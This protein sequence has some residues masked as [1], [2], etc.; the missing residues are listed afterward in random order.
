[1]TPEYWI[2]LSAI[3]ALI[4]ASAFFSGSETAL[5]AA[6][7]ARMHLLEKNG[8]ARAATVNALIARRDRLIGALLIGNNL[9]NILASVL[10]TSF[11]LKMFGDSGLAIATVAMTVVIVIFAEITPKS[12][13]ISSADKFA[14]AVAPAVNLIVTVLT[15]FASVTSFIVRVLLRPF[16]IRFDDAQ[17]MLSAHEEI[18]GAVE[19]LHREGSVVRDD[20]YRLGGILDLHE[21][22]VSDVM[23][24]RTKM[25]SINCDDPVDSIVRQILDSPY[26][27][28]PVWKNE[29][30]NI[31]GI[32]HAKDVLRFVGANED[33]SKF[34]IMKIAAKPW[35]VPETT[36]LQDQLNAFLRKK[37][38]IALVVD[39]YGEVKGLVTLEDILEEIV[40]E[41]ADE[42]DVEVSGV[43]TQA[44][45]SVIVDGSVPIRDLNRALD[46]ELPDDEATTVAG[47]VIHAAQ[48]I[49]EEK[50]AFTFYGKRF[51]VMHRERNRLTQLR[52]RNL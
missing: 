10:A 37:A 28:I 4:V 52:I 39:E 1:M 35:F 26:T 23:I 22:E 3:V 25:L 13:A 19:V 33:L 5:T 49:P 12:W 24:H 50:Q 32:V 31:I 7:R 14:L 20:R 38:H 11:F 42:H 17:S 51:V 9:V 44:D 6:S 29:V 15:P 47:L 41:I 18:R 45:G 46:W 43:Q 21:L 36:T 34:D 16:G 2:L 30:E 27:R 48:T 40:G 8:D